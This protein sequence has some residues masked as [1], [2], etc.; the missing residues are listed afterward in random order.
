MSAALRIVKAG[1]GVS[2]QDKGRH[3]FLRFGVTPAGPM[4]SGGFIAALLAAGDTK[5]AAI[6]VSL[7]GVEIEAEGG[8]IGLAI[9][10]GAFDIRLD[11]RA[12]HSA[13]ALKLV[14]GARLSVFDRHTNV[15]TASANMPME[16]SGAQWPQAMQQFDQLQQESQARS[17]ALAQVQDQSP[18]QAQGMGR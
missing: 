13:C 1:P 6:E 11:D 3:G 12:L 17:Q 7:G 18:Q 4:D 5:E 15:P 14:P 9:A 2:V 10:G 16:Q 8:D